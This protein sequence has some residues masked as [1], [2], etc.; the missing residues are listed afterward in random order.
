MTLPPWAEGPFELIYHAELHYRAGEDFDR[1]IAMISFDNAIEVSI[2]TYLSLHPLQRQ[3][4][5]YQTA[6]VEKWLKNY[7]SKIEF[8]EIECQQRGLT[9]VVQRPHIVWYHA[10]RNDQYHKGGSST[11]NRSDLQGAR[12]AALWIFSVLYDVPDVEQ[13]LEERIAE[14]LP[15]PPT[16]REE[17]LDR[18]ID[19]VHGMVQIAGATYYVS[20]VLFGLDA[21][22]Y[23]DMGLQILNSQANDGVE[24][25]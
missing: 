17:R 5:T 12:Q 8:F 7:H 21:T 16:L 23:R 19:N 25:E 13:I 3:N 2:T 9:I 14:A 24:P 20:E 6:D 22:L 18:A 11:P 1:R 10:I 15:G 4:R